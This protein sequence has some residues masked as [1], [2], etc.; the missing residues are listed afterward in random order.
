MNAKRMITNA[1]LTPMTMFPSV[2]LLFSQ[3]I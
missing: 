2:E 3:R 1:A